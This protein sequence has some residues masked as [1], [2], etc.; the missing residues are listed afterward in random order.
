RPHVLHGELVGQVSAA[1]PDRVEGMRRMHAPGE[2]AVGLGD[3]LEPSRLVARIER[4]RELVVAPAV[5]QE[6]PR[7]HR[8]GFLRIAREALVDPV[9]LRTRVELEA[10]RDALGDDEEIALAV[11]D[12]AERRLEYARALV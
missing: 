12:G 7:S 6:L 1:P 5:G 9:V 3:D 4:A 8:L 11:G 2:G 10:V